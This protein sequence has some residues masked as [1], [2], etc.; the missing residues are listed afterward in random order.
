MSD[1]WTAGQ[2]M[3]DWRFDQTLNSARFLLGKERARIVILPPSSPG[4]NGRP[5]GEWKTAPIVFSAA[6]IYND[7]EDDRDNNDDND[8]DDALVT[9][10]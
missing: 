9:T 3:S 10:R 4:R 2:W 7:A 5:D 8:V 6:A 1:Q